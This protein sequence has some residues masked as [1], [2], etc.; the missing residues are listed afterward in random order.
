MN[1]RVINV[2]PERVLEGIAL[3]GYKKV[4]PEDQALFD[5]YYD[6]MNHPWSGSTEFLNFIAWSDTLPV[7][8]KESDG[9]IIG[10]SYE[11]N[12]GMLVGIPFIGHYTN[13]SVKQAF[14]IMKKDFETIG[15]PL[16]IMDVTKWML[17]YYESVDGFSF[18]IEDKREYMEYIYTATDFE[19]G[20]DKQDD[21][22]RYR[23]FM[24]KFDY[25]V[26]EIKSK[27]RDEI[28]GF[29]ERIWCGGKTCSE[30]QFGCMVEVT[31]RVVSAFDELEVNGLL[32]R[33]DGEIAGFCIVTKRMGQAIYQ[34]KHAIN[35]IK[36]INEY[37]LRE[38][39][40]RYL[41]GVDIVNYTE[42]CGIE[43][44][45]RYKMNLATDYSLLSRLTLIQSDN[46][47]KVHN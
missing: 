25:E 7:Y 36:G 46:K 43:S 8:F 37:M 3:C 12:E 4:E 38:C 26:E 42:D 11:S 34:F 40:E 2:I 16:V 20:L 21:R 47:M 33:V 44:L 35:R 14:A 5:P 22:Y 13:E 32:V 9:M 30:C 15:E 45:R 31:D 19:A 28:V 6:K 29:M 39:Y 10:L 41:K 18:D 23:Y 1:T 24:R 17:P 27:H